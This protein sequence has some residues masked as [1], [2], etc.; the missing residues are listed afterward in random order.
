MNPA[1]FSPQA[2]QGAPE[3]PTPEAIEQ[4][5]VENV[6]HQPLGL[7]TVEDLAMPEDFL[8][9][10]ADRIVRS[11]YEERYRIVV[12]DGPRAELRAMPSVLVLAGV[13][14]AVLVAIVVA[15]V[16]VRGRK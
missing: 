16:R 3:V 1:P 7:G 2:A 11:S 10:V 9:R 15:V 13:G 4:E 12:K 6:K 14:L 8:R 5:V